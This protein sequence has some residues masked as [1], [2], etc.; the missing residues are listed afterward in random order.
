[1]YVCK[2][3]YQQFQWASRAHWEAVSSYPVL[4]CQGD[5][6]QITPL[7]GAQS[8]MKL[9]LLKSKEKEGL[10]VECGDKG[11]TK[12]S[13]AAERSRKVRL[14]VISKSGHHTME[15]QPS[16]LATHMTAFFKEECG[17]SF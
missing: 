2:A 9:L 6:D 1:M 12:S 4:I 8:L 14:A 11:E 13:S 16:Q 3:F 17:I 15:E 5:D 10:S 7:D